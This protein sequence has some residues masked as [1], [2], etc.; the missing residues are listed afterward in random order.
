MGAVGKS[1]ANTSATHSNYI[2]GSNQE[3]DA[4]A[5]ICRWEVV[6]S[7]SDGPSVD[8][9]YR[10]QKVIVGRG[11]LFGSPSII[12]LSRL[13]NLRH[14]K[15]TRCRFTRAQIRQIDRGAS[16]AP[17]FPKN[18]RRRN[19]TCHAIAAGER[20]RDRDGR[21]GSASAT[22]T[23]YVPQ[24][25]ESPADLMRSVRPQTED[26]LSEQSTPAEASTRADDEGRDAEVFSDRPPGG[27][28]AAP[29]VPP[30]NLESY[31]QQL[32]ARGRED[33]AIGN[34]ES[35]ASR[36]AERGD[37]HQRGICPLMFSILV[38]A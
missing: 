37:H 2:W 36:L 25:F 14:S 33:G 11:R 8:I 10:S 29:P 4:M 15:G 7:T 34:D 12:V 13:H 5:E 20:E 9:L 38:S 23:D 30:L 3:R 26:S 28:G 22:S 18:N 17:K 6:V 32:E 1:G 19:A 16:S 27:S 24:M 31:L 35:G 21:G